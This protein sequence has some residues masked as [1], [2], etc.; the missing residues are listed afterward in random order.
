MVVAS[1]IAFAVIGCGDSEEGGAGDE[2][3]AETEVAVPEEEKE[4]AAQAA[5]LKEMVETYAQSEEGIEKATALRA[6]IE[7]Q[8]ENENFDEVLARSEESLAVK[9]NE[10]PTWTSELAYAMVHEGEGAVDKAI[11]AYDRVVSHYA[12]MIA[13]S[14]PAVRRGAELRWERNLPGEGA[15]PSDRQTAYTALHRYV[16]TTGRLQEHFKPHELASWKEAEKLA[17]TY[18]AHADTVPITAP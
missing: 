17:Q 8:L 12:G 13:F 7:F 3:P 11:E 18:D 10:V 16:R 9:L 14:A 2:S 15:E 1:L 4:R 6:I 5:R